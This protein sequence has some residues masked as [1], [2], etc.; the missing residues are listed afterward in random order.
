ILH[1]LFVPLP[2]GTLTVQIEVAAGMTGLR[3][4]LAMER[5]LGGG[6]ASPPGASPPGVSPPR[7]ALDHPAH[8]TPLDALSRA[9][10]ALW[11][12]RQRHPMRRTAEL[13]PAPEGELTLEEAGCALVPPPRHLRIELPMAPTLVSF[14]RA[15]LTG[16]YRL[17]EVWRL[18]DRLDPRRGAERR[19]V[20]LARR[21]TRGWADEGALVLTSSPRRVAR[22]GARPQIEDEV[23]MV[24]GERRSRV[25]QRWVVDADGVVFRVSASGPPELPAASYREEV[26]GALATW[27]RLDEV[28]PA[29]ARKRPWWLGG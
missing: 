14:S 27:R 15:A 22:F 8:D 11:S 20:D 7:A 9:R 17:F 10:K 3:E 18:P 4:V 28:G 19:L 6:G 13:P 16:G 21:T 12:F 1:E 25:L 26:L 24:A 2:K 5:A 29:P 23:S